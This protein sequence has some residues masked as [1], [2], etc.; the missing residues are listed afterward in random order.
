[1]SC[2][3]NTA[4]YEFTGRSIDNINAPGAAVFKSLSG[5]AKRR[6]TRRS[7]RRTTRRK[8]KKMTG[9]RAVYREARRSTRRSTRKAARKTTRK[10]RTSRRNA[11]RGSKYRRD[12]SKRRNTRRRN[13]SKRR[14]TRR[15]NVSKRRNTRERGA[16]MW[17]KPRRAVGGAADESVEEPLQPMPKGA[18][19]SNA[20]VPASS[21]PP[22]NTLIEELE[23][24]AK[25]QVIMEV[26]CGNVGDKMKIFPP[27][28]SPAP[29]GSFAMV[30][31]PTGCKMGEKWQVDVNTSWPELAPAVWWLPK[32]KERLM[33]LYTKVTE[34][35][36]QWKDLNSDAKTKFN[37]WWRTFF[38]EQVGGKD[39][40]FEDIW[41]VLVTSTTHPKVEWWTEDVDKRLD[42][43]EKMQKAATNMMAHV[44]KAAGA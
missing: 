1:M 7:T 43:I 13:V 9:R 2:A 16:G 35:I 17:R 34:L 20:P 8:S 6:S 18:L 42:K 12:V 36:K 10:G 38:S 14:N 19:R 22:L 27:E 33:L 40:T 39:K 28:G 29:P 15:S 5:G 24:Q 37:D 30:K 26:P 21:T 31:V 3:P 44:T 41:N 23:K 4:A 11:R 32:A 25:V